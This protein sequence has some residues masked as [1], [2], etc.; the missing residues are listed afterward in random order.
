MN[1]AMAV[2]LIASFAVVLGT[3]DLEARRAMGISL[4]LPAVVGER[5]QIFIS[6]QHREV[7]K[8]KV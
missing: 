5:M 2:G 1:I 3:S 4:N 7:I 8:A 6:T